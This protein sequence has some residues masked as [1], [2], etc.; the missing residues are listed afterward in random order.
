MIEGKIK[1]LFP[2]GGFATQDLAAKAALALAYPPS[3]VRTA[4]DPIGVEHGGEL[5]TIGGIHSF[6]GPRKGD[7]LGVSV[8]R[9]VPGF[10]GAYHSHGADSGGNLTD[11]TFSPPDKRL[12]DRLRTPGYLATPTGVMMRYDP[13][14][15][16][17]LLGAVT[18]I[19][20]LPII[21]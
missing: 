15:G 19:G 3:V 18:V 17:P 13:K 16:A 4:K 7:A 9:S 14:P 8:N 10:S 21:P 5:V 2:G 20:T 11:Y 6:T 1:R 12:F